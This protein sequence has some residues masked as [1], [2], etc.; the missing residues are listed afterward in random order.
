MQEFVEVVRAPWSSVPPYKSQAD[1]KAAYA[2]NREFVDGYGRAVCKSDIDAGLNIRLMVR[3]GGKSGID[4]V[5][6][7]N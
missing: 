6:I 2:A 1:V 7:V 4:K 5:F 3:Y